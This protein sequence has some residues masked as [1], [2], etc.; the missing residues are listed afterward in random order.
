[1]QSLQNTNGHAR[2][3]GSIP[4]SAEGVDMMEAIAV[5]GFSMRFPQEATTA[6]GFW[7]I[8]RQGR[9]V[10]TEVPPDRFN[11]NGFYHPDASRAG[12]VSTRHSSSVGH[13][14]I[15]S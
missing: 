9:S 1:M 6:E 4:K 13:D 10:M 8:L 12:T 11:I 14:L 5:I 15:V 2:N 3:N 7:D